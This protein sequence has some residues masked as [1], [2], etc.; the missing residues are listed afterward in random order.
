LKAG[1]VNERAK[2]TSIIMRDSDLDDTY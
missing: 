1:A 2:K